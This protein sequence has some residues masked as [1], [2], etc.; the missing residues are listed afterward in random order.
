MTREAQ[1]ETIQKISKLNFDIAWNTDELRREQSRTFQSPPAAPVMPEMRKVYP[2]VKSNR[3]Y[4]WK[5]SFGVMGAG[6]VMSIMLGIISSILPVGFFWYLVSGANVFITSASFLW[7]I[8]FTIWW[9]GKR[10]QDV[11]DTLNSAEYKAKCAQIDKEFEES[12]SRATAVYNNAVHEYKTVT[13]PMYNLEKQKFE[14]VRNAAV[15]KLK[16]ALSEDK[17]TLNAIYDETKILPSPYR[18]E[19]S[20]EFIKEY[21][22]TSNGTV[23][24]AILSYD[25]KLQMD[26]DNQKLA[27]QIRQNDINDRMAYAQEAANDIAERN[28]EIAEQSRRDANRAAFVA[29]VQRHNT[30]KQ[31]KRM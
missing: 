10:K 15:Q 24:D 1:L 31:L 29:A 12:V 4:D 21:M 6:I 5:T 14:D 19:R 11:Y 30:N 8:G 20:V 9:Y 22:E 26:L 3:K 28:N 23:E 25:R 13:I 18:S 7:P 17:C 27:E 2:V 16:K